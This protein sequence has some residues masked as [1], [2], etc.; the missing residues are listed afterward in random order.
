MATITALFNATLIGSIIRYRTTWRAHYVWERDCRRVYRMRDELKT[1]VRQAQ[2]A[3]EREAR[4]EKS[5]RSLTSYIFHELRVPLNIANLARG[6][7]LEEG[8][9]HPEFDVEA[10]ALGHSLETMAQVLNDVLD[11]HRME[12][13]KFRCVRRPYAFHRT[14]GAALQGLAL[15]AQ[16]KGIKL[17]REF[18]HDIDVLA[19]QEMVLAM[20]QRS[21][22]GDKEPGGDDSGRGGTNTNILSEEASGIVVGDANRLRQIMNNLVSN[23][24]KFTD[25]GGTITVRTK[26]LG[27]CWPPVG[28]AADGEPLTPKTSN[29]NAKSSSEKTPSTD[30]TVDLEALIQQ[31]ET[32]ATG[33]ENTR[34]RRQM[35]IR[36]EVEDSGAGIQKKWVMDNRLFSPYVQ[37]ELGRL[38]GGK[39][40]GLGLALIKNIVKFSGG[41]LGVKS[42][43]TKGSTFWVELPVGIG[44]I[45]NPK[46]SRAIPPSIQPA[47]QEATPPQL[48]REAMQN[49]EN[50]VPMGDPTVLT[51]SDKRAGP[52]L[53]ESKSSDQIAS[54]AKPPSP[55][56]SKSAPQTFDP[57]LEVLVVDDDPMTRKLMERMLTRNGCKVSTSDN[58]RSGLEMALGVSTPFLSRSPTPS[59]DLLH[60]P[61]SSPPQR[62]DIMFVDNQMPIMSGVEMVRNLRMLGRKDMLIGVTGNALKED[63]VEYSQAGANGVLIK[64]VQERQLVDYLVQ[65]AAERTR[66]LASS[67]HIV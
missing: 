1:Q 44:P 38:Q 9:I 42:Q 51:T 49:G 29:S 27:C 52:A 64:P 5:K 14:L 50:R 17:R 11:F 19:D 20:A 45:Q 46:P 25:R 31:Q 33:T 40:S 57:P 15:G 56:K 65:A 7:L 62:W 66:R 4:L 16:A 24:I 21:D 12:S 10:E 8:G 54:P 2:R 39:G 35:I 61:P 67:P 23:A 55:K 63:Q 47:E 26:C 48:G 6:N 58:G 34:C 18:D 22:L 60:P 41:R 28:D 59:L 13:G 43:F 37:T 36:I 32:D 3:R 30:T 53:N